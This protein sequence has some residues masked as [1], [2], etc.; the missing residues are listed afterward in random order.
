MKR[1]GASLVLIEQVIMLLVFALAAA[2]CL[3]AFVWADTESA[4]VAER[5]KAMLRAQNAAEVIKNE[6]D[7]AAAGFLGGKAEGERWIISYDGEWQPAE[8]VGVYTLTAE[9]KEDELQYMSAACVEIYKGEKLLASL[10]VA[11]QEVAKDEG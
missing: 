7:V 9:P 6:G 11:W 5:D 1:S 8:G 10:D 3:K 4:A 2:L